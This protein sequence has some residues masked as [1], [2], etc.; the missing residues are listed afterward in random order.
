MLRDVRIASRL[1]KENKVIKDII[2]RDIRIL[3]ENE[4][5]K[6]CY[7]PV[8]VSSF[9]SSSFIECKSNGN[10]KRILSVEEYLN[11]IRT[12]LKDII[13]NLKKFDTWKTQLTKANNFI[14][15]KEFVMHSK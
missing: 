2:V 1:E 14:S 3:F 10:R 15:S 4:E 5:V 8:R 12:Y 11:K 7:K 13:N 6:N 9:Q